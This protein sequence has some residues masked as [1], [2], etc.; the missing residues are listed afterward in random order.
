MMTM[1]VLTLPFESHGL[2]LSQF[3]GSAMNL[4]SCRHVQERNPCSFEDVIGI[5]N[6]EGTTE[7]AGGN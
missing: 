6:N 5:S 2:P 7:S 1:S 4:A 3:T